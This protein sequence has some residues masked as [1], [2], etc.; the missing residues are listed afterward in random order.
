MTD[1]EVGKL[2]EDVYLR[3][4]DPEMEGL[5]LKLIEEMARF[6]L[7]NHPEGCICEKDPMHHFASVCADLGIPWEEYLVLLSQEGERFDNKG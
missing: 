2:W 4:D 5:L 3:R 1:A 6:D 7:W